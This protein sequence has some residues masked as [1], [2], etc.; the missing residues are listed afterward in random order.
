MTDDYNKIIEMLRVNEENE[1]RAYKRILEIISGNE[2]ND[3]CE[4]VYAILGAL[5]GNDIGR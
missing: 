2:Y 1:N 3:T 4:K 5:H